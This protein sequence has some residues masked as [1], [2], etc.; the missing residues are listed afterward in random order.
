MLLDPE[1]ESFSYDL[2][3]EHVTISSLAEALAVPVE[4]L[5]GYAAETRSDPELGRELSR[6]V[7][8]RIEAKRRMP[9][10]TRLPWYL[11]V[12]AKKPAVVVE[13]GIHMGLGSL[14]LLRALERNNAEGHPGELLS[15][16][17]SRHA[18][19]LVRERLRE[20]WQRYHGSTSQTLRPALDGREVGVLFQD[21]IH[22]EENQ[23]HEFGAALDHAAQELLLIDCSSGQ[24]GTLQRLCAER[25]GVFHTVPLRS[26]DHVFPGADFTFGSFRR[27]S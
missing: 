6:H 13:T 7:R 9:I 14:T 1:L 26:R 19:W 11:I 23:L 20:P 27:A 15:F 22:T 21:T 8:W 12:R 3:D 10:G 24:A 5:E 16:D 4:E 18:G 2:R 25:G 17:F